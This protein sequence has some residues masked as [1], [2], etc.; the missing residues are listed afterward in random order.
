M[1]EQAARLI[2]RQQAEETVIFTARRRPIGVAI[3][4]YGA[5]GA[6]AGVPLPPFF[7]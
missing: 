1:R 7:E 3:E 2:T 4:K 5:R 6:I